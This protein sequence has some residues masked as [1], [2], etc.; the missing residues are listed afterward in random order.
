[1]ILGPVFVSRV[2]QGDTKM[3]HEISMVSM[4]Q[5]LKASSYRWNWWHLFATNRRECSVS[6]HTYYDRVLEIEGVVQWF[7]S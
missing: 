7:S 3:T 6:F 1:M 4:S 5:M 2:G